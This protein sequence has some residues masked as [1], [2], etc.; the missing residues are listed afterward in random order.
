MG[1]FRTA[2]VHL[3]VSLFVGMHA[4]CGALVR[5]CVQVPLMAALPTAQAAMDAHRGVVAVGEHGLGF[6]RNLAMA[7]A[8]KVS[9]AC[10][11]L[12]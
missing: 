9:L 11:R 7:E 8:N 4:V 5:G 10:C 12:R 2:L 6:L 1:A 3:L